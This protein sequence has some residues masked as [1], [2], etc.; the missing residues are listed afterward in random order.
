MAS[1]TPQVKFYIAVPLYDA[2]MPLIDAMSKNGRPPRTDKPKKTTLYLSEEAK[3][4]I[5]S[6]ACSA[7]QSLSIA[8]D[9]II[10]AHK[11]R[12]NK[13]SVQLRKAA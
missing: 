5:F 11:R 8:A 10:L 12:A 7:R 3:N 13:K 4:F 1:K 2:I 9:E 6:L